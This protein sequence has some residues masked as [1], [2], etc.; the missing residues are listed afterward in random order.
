MS[1]SPFSLE[2]RTILV[3]GASSG[4]G[5]AV[6]QAAAEMGAK[7]VLTGRDEK[8]LDAC[9]KTLSGGDHQAFISDLTENESISKLVGE[10]PEIDGLAFS[11]GY[12]EVVPFRMV[13][14]TH[15]DRIMQINF[16]APVL[17]TQGLL[18]Q[19]KIRNGASLVY[20]SAVADHICPAGSAIYSASKAALN[21]AIKSMALE[22]AKFKIRANSVSPGYVNTPMLER[23]NQTSSLDELF[24]LSPLGL[25]EASD[26]AHS[27]VYLLSPAARWVTRSVL[28]VDAGISLP[29]R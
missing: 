23:L 17:L 26:V 3:T 9:L 7:L 16:N 27:V 25:A 13:S 11:A 24:K 8:R 28:T 2:G 4:I 1:D 6:A 21:A 15:I 20:V 29:A 5:Q 19:K 12:A 22:L 14:S 10:L 18:K